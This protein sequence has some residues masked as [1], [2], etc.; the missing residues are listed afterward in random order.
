MHQLGCGV[1]VKSVLVRNIEKARTVDI[2]ENIL[3]TNPNDVLQD[4]EIDVV[5]EVMGGV[6]EARQYLL[7]AFRAK[8]HVV[9]ANKDLIALHGPELEEV[10]AQNG[11]DLFY[12]ASVGGGIPLLRGLTDR[13]L[14]HRIYHVKVGF[15]HR[16]LLHKKCNNRFLSHF[17]VVQ[18]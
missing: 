11:C 5:V 7:E 13:T 17:A 3:T 9:T 16:H 4:P 6:E 10:A 1:K 15:H 8:K 18:D 12:E 14:A 2:D